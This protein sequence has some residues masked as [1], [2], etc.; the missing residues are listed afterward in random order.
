MSL[1]QN[2]VNTIRCLAA[3]VVQNAESGHPGAPMGLAPLGHILWTRIMNFNPADTSWPNRDRYIQSN[4]HSSVLLYILLHLSGSGCS[5]DDLQHYRQLLCRTPGHPEAGLLP[6]VE[7]L[8]RVNPHGRYF[9][10][11]PPSHDGPLGQGVG[12][13][14][15]M[16]IAQAHLAARFNVEHFPVFDHYIYAVCSDGDMMEGISHEAASVAGHLRL[17]RLVWIYDNNGHTIDGPTS[18]TYSDDIVARFQSYGWHTQIVEDGDRDLSAIQRA[19]ENVR[20]V[21]NRPHFISL[22]TTIGYGSSKAGSEK[23]HGTP[24]GEEDL[25]ETKRRLGMDPSHRFVVPNAVREVYASILEKGRTKQAAWQAMLSQ[26]SAQFPDKFRE[27]ERLMHNELPPDWEAALPSENPEEKPQGTRK[28]S[29]I[30]LE[31]LFPALSGLIGGS[32]DLAESTG[33]KRNGSFQNN[34]VN[35][36]IHF[37]VREHVMMAI[38]N[39]ISSY[40]VGLIPFASTFLIFAGYCLPSVRLAALSSLRV[41]F[42][43]SHDSVGLGGD[44]PTHQP[45]E[46]LETLRS[47]PKMVV[48]RPCSLNETVGAYRWALMRPNQ[49]TSFIFSRQNVKYVSET[50]RDISRGAYILRDTGGNPDIILVG[51]GSEVPLCVD[52]ARSLEPG[53]H[54]RVISAPALNLFDKQPQ[55]YKRSLFPLGVP[56]LSVEASC[57]HGW[58]SYSHAHVGVDSFGLSAPGEE[59]LKF[60]GFTVD[61]VVAKAHRLH[62]WYQT[63]P[64]PTLFDE[65]F[66]EMRAT[67]NI[68]ATTGTCTSVTNPEPAAPMGAGVS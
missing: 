48:I 7:G 42:I 46:M 64:V 44:G 67:E 2:C 34:P 27:L 33:I 31:A 24:L 62:Q 55:E 19:L 10:A 56:V 26:Y 29:G 39:G 61:N 25:A 43:F 11:F 8:P 28:M 52:A 59:V 20:L 18:L 3:D 51:T 65:P 68:P 1:D 37:G 35:R 36:L 49:P 13:S 38:C 16:A 5:M 14:V 30:V 6:G 58:A 21:P 41:L 45:I 12:N 66:G 22:R 47:I 57:C 54:T 15:G 23:T 17:N 32:A 50:S 60:L 40:R 4:G 9:L 53:L 63:H